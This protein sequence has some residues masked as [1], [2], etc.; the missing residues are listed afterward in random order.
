MNSVKTKSAISGG[1]YV[2]G[3]IVL[4]LLAGCQLS[5]DR[6]NRTQDVPTFRIADPL[7]RVF[8]SA[9][10]VENSSTVF[11]VAAN[12][13]T[14]AGAGG[15]SVA[16]QMVFAPDR[17]G[18]R[19]RLELK[20]FHLV[21]LDS[22]DI[23]RVVRTIEPAVT[24]WYKV[25]GV[26]VIGS[27]TVWQGQAG[28]AAV[29]PDALI[30]LVSD[31][32]GQA[33]VNLA[34]DKLTI[35]WVELRLPKGLGQ[36]VYASELGVGLEKSLRTVAVALR[37]WGFDLAG[38]KAPG[39]DVRL[40]ALVNAARLW[41]IY[42][43]GEDQGTGALTISDQTPNLESLAEVA[44]EYAE[45]LSDHGIEPWLVG[46]FPR[47]ATDQQG[48]EFDWSG[49]TLLL[50]RF[51]QAGRIDH[52]YWPVPVE[53]SFPPTQLFGLYDSPG[54]RVYLH[55]YLE[56]FRK[57][58]ATAGRLGT[59]LGV[60]VWPEDPL[61]QDGMFD[62][63]R[64]LAE[65]LA[66][67]EPGLVILDPFIANDLKP[68]GFSEFEFKDTGKF[69]NILCPPGGWW[70]P[71]AMAKLRETGKQIWWR[72]GPAP[73]VPDLAVTAPYQFAQAIP[74]I[75]WRYGSTGVVITDSVGRSNSLDK[76]LEFEQA[77]LSSRWLIYPGQWFSV[78]KP[79]PT[80]R[81]KMLQ[82]GLQ[83]VAYLNA[84]GSMKSRDGKADLAEFL[85]HHLVRFAHTDALDGSL[86]SLRTDGLC[87]DYRPWALARMIAGR[88]LAKPGEGT[89]AEVE[90]AGFDSSLLMEQFR[91][92]SED[93]VLECQGIKAS[94]R[95]DLD[96]EQAAINWTCYL[97]MRNYRDER[98][99]GT[100]GFADTSS[101]MTFPEAAFKVADLDWGYPL[102]VQ[103]SEQ[104]RSTSVNM[105][106]IASRDVVFRSDAG[107]EI[108]LNCR[109]NALLVPLV[110][111]DTIQIDGRFE[112]WSEPIGP[113]A[114]DFW[115]IVSDGPEQMLFGQPA[116]RGATWSTTVQVAHD[117]QNLYF[118]F[119]CEQ[120][121]GS[122]L[123]RYSNDI[124]MRSGHASGED[125]VEVLIDPDNRRTLD[126]KDAYHIVVKGNGAVISCRGLPAA[127]MGGSYPWPNHAHAAVKIFD[128]YWQ[129]E[130][131]VPLADLG[132]VDKLDRWWGVDLVRVA[133][134]IGE[135]SSWS[136][137]GSQ[138]YVP[139]SFGNM[140]LAR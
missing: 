59:P 115:R 71:A 125:L 135:I 11:D 140:L 50:D 132:A 111:P 83:D 28:G 90:P 46:A 98:V 52:R 113:V 94:R 31:S 35:V 36:G 121:P 13:I 62:A 79:V 6:M 119:R 136:G 116:S 87:R 130:I 5:A 74:W 41:N 53:M 134:S 63:W 18:R 129:V 109:S 99:S 72:P 15:E 27:G 82:R 66:G 75:A 25:E 32:S 133:G 23:E 104:S 3:L 124:E 38:S 88:E 58:F 120:P 78:A 1:A 16:F 17:A 108:V 9:G 73:A 89:R 126:P 19:V 93:L 110:A 26:K 39:E 103:L 96:S 65:A 4:G 95:V 123:V 128:D 122:R 21:Q 51:L 105:F 131:A 114:G 106:G 117:R 34:A 97:A 137:A 33:S 60:F 7:E 86:W 138:L 54:Y 102:L 47:I 68:F 56:E 107:Q 49:Y 77:E 70:N 101:G 118:A 100:L 76:P 64:T 84:L 67:S 45:L 10:L 127:S 30:P 40:F 57:Q 69:A 139:I 81:L 85:A 2:S 12:Q 92:F 44:G 42:K 43:L 37:S 80:I 8:A 14:L 112:D 48:I 29:F 22:K 61:T 20:P 55:R 91:Q 24:R